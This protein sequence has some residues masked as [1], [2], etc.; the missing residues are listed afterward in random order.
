[1]RGRHY[2]RRNYKNTL[3]STYGDK[4]PGPDR[5]PNEFYSAFAASLAPLLRD[6]YNEARNSG[7]VPKGFQDGLVTLLYKKDLEQMLETTGPLLSSI[8]NTKL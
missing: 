4:S 6:V 5:R 3:Q 2:R 7:K 1:M 8:V